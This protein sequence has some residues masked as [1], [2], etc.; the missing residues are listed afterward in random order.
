M[1]NNSYTKNYADGSALTEAKLDTAYQSLKL[2]LGNTT[3]MTQGATA[4][5]YL[6]C[7]TPGAAAQFAALPALTGPSTIRNYGIKCT[8]AS[9]AL[10]FTLT[11][12]AGATPSASDAVDIS[13]SSAGST[14]AT[15]SDLSVTTTKTITLNSSA[16]LGVDTIGSSISTAATLVY[17]YAL[18]SGSSIL[19]GVSRNPNL[20]VGAAVTTVAL[21]TSADS[22]VELYATAAL[23][24]IPK[25]LGAATAAM[26][27][28]RA[29]QTPSAVALTQNLSSGVVSGPSFSITATSAT[30]VANATTASIVMKSTGRP[31]IFSLTSLNTTSAN[32]T[33]KVSR[34]SNT[35]TM[36]A[37]VQLLRG[38]ITLGIWGLLTG[39]ITYDTN[40]DV[41][42]PV[43]FTV[44]DTPPAGNHTYSV[45]LRASTSVTASISSVRL[46]GCSL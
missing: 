20:D 46:V 30:Y 42:T 39:D 23:S 27:S 37:R 25:L 21:S 17:L 29:W 33:L 12:G 11:T 6:K 45:R 35:G 24:V 28:S 4:G 14:S 18:K 36:E 1:A 31:I 43:C 32:S 41:R 40:Q 9:G 10:V 26:N 13:F 16:T 15:Q 34:G 22:A 44:F 3:Q 38:T 5:Q 2:D 7:I 8:A 19:L